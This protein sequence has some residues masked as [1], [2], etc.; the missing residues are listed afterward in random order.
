MVSK[1]VEMLEDMLTSL[2]DLL[3]EKGLITQEEYEAKVRVMLEESE[4]LT[5]FDDLD[6]K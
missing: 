6:D 1:E 4:G 5:R 3:V 2:V